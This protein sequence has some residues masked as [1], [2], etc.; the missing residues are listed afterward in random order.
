MISTV[1][2]QLINNIKADRTDRKKSTEV[3]TYKYK[4]SRSTAVRTLYKY[5]L[6]SVKSIRKPGLSNTQRATRLDFCLKH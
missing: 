6:L 4:T 1:E 5:S 3:L 2:Q